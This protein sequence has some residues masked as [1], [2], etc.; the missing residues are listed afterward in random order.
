MG[1]RLRVLAFGLVLAA[2][3]PWSGAQ[4]APKQ[5]VETVQVGVTEY[6]DIIAKWGAPA[7]NK[8]APDG[9]RTLVYA[10]TETRVRPVTFVPV[11]NLVG[12]GGKT[13]INRQTLTFGPDGKLV[14]LT[15]A[16]THLECSMTGGCSG[17]PAN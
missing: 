5:V 16:D 10:W 13:E 15:K 2:S 6:R 7:E 14:S 17:A 3:G 8:L 12:G 11:L 9:T 1:M 4:A